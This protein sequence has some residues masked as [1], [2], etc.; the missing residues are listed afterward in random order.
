MTRDYPNSSSWSEAK[1]RLTRLVDEVRERQGLYTLE[2]LFD[3]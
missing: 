3:R 2:E 1:A